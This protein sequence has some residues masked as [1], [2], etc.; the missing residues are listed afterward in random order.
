MFESNRGL[1]TGEQ[2]ERATANHS[3]MVTR[4]LR[5]TVRHL[6]TSIA[7]IGVILQKTSVKVIIRMGSQETRDDDEVRMQIVCSV[8]AGYLKA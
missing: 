5:P 2:D 8:K 1:Q 7:T 4:Q 6:T 3:N